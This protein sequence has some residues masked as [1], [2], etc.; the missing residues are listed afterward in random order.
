MKKKI[1]QERIPNKTD[2][3]IINDNRIFIFY[4]ILYIKRED[5]EHFL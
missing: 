1:I 2:H 4:I 5:I 3:D